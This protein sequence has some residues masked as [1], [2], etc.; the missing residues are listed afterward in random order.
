MLATFIGLKFFELFF[1]LLLGGFIGDAG[2]MAAGDTVFI[3]ELPARE[4]FI[5]E[6]DAIAAE[7][8]S[9]LS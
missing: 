8:E 3:G 4:G 2:G 6:L 5:I 7:G 9:V 1:A